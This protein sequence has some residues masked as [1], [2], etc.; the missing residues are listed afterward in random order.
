MTKLA[1]TEVDA[2]LHPTS[3]PEQLAGAI[4]LAAAAQES[5]TSESAESAAGKYA[6][7]CENV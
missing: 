4:S 3:G 6:K 5:I 1:D 2:E 7:M